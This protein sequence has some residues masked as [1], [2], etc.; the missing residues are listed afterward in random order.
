MFKMVVLL[1]KKDGLMDAEFAKYWLEK[2]A[3]LAK[4]MPGLRKYVVNVVKPPPNREPDYNGLV[5]LWFDDVESMKKAFNSPQGGATQKDTEA[6]T[7][8]I[9][10]LFIDEHQVM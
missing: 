5:E 8:Q 7:S 10:T 9:T 1:K 4:Q 6:F 3:P 2:H